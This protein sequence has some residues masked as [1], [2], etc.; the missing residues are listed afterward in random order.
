M[1]KSLQLHVYSFISL[2]DCLFDP[3]CF[4][5]KPQKTAHNRWTDDEVQALLST[6][7]E[8][9]I[10]RDR[11][12][13]AVTFIAFPYIISPKEPLRNPKGRGYDATFQISLAFQKY[14]LY[15]LKRK[16]KFPSLTFQW[17]NAKLELIVI[18]AA[19]VF[20]QTARQVKE[21]VYLFEEVH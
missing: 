14:E 3:L 6:Y 12:C 10:Q 20:H 4:E 15:K 19:S 1:F 13:S 2:R 5:M 21:V 16:F 11:R 7:A 9:D 8:E 17:S 18:F